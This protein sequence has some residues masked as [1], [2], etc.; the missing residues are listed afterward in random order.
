MF[1]YLLVLLNI[2]MLFFTFSSF[3][4]KKKIFIPLAEAISVFLCIFAVSSGITWIFGVFSVEFCLMAVTFLIIVVSVYAYYKSPFKGKEFFSLGKIGI[5]HRVVFNKGAILIATFLSLGAFSTAGVGFND[6]NAQAVALSIL[7]GNNI[8]NIKISEYQDIEPGSRYEYFFYEAVTDIEKENFTANYHLKKNE[9]LEGKMD[10]Y[11]DFGTNPVYPSLL[12]LS[13]TLFGTGRMAF[14][15]AIFAFCTFVF[16]DEILKVLKCDWKLRSLLILLLSVSPIIVYCNHTTLVEPIIGFCMVMF[17]YFLFCKENKLQVLSAIG[18]VTFSFIHT[19]VYTMLPLFLVVYWMYYVHSRKIRHLLALGIS[20]AGYILSFVFLNF[21]AYE[22]TLINYRLGIPFL[23]NY[24]FI[25]VI[26]IAAIATIVSVILFVTLRKVNPEKISQFE[27][28]KGSNIFKIGVIIATVAA[29]IFMVVVNIFKCD[30]FVD[31]MNITLIA[32]AVCTGIIIVPYIIGRLLSGSYNLGIREAVIVVTFIYT[33]LLY[34][35]VMRIT[36]DGY[37]YEARYLS[38]FIPFIILTAGMMFR[39]LKEDEKYFIP[40]I[41][42]IILFIPFTASLLSPDAEKRLDRN[43]FEE[44]NKTVEDKADEN[45]VIL[46]EKSLMKYFYYPLLNKTE[47]KVYPFEYS[48]AQSFILDTK[49]ASSKVLLISDY[50]GNRYKHRGAIRFLKTFTPN[51]VS[52]EDLS[53]ITGLP[54]AFH[55]GKENIVQVIELNNLGKIVEPDSIDKFEWDL[56]DL[57][58]KEVEIDDDCMAHVTVSLTDKTKLY[59]N[60]D[61]QLFLSY[62]LDYEESEDIYDNAR[63][64]IGPVVYADYIYDFNLAEIDEDLTVVID[65]VEEGVEWYSWKNKAPAIDF[66]K[67]EDGWEYTLYSKKTR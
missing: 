38:S 23:K 61:D 60:D 59:Y 55:K 3:S 24:Y 30:S 46:I 21:V 41:G 6:G 34:S 66:V 20:T 11:L 54:N 26:I 40:I 13:A 37:Y 5:D 50:Q 44:V 35:S 15:Q 42:I 65:V 51:E 64:E 63:T 12:A 29:L 19:S 39:L 2:V 17:V 36:I 57:S 25:F 49:D 43:I 33:I 53:A 16:V 9:E 4:D 14:I 8:R 56:M 32:F 1:V 47:A 52:K 18:I 7:N 45:T 67:K 10:I 28:S 27:K 31:T 48:Y 22:N 58:V 62:H